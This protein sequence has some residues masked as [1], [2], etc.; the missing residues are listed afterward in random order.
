MIEKQFPVGDT[1]RYAAKCFFENAP[2]SHNGEWY[3]VID[4]RIE[5]NKVIF[6]LMG[7]K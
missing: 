4:Y 3:N 5:N 2:F 1:A 7:I 6:T